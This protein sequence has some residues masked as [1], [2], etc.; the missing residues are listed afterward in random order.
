MGS[1]RADPDYCWL[2]GSAKPE[3][4]PLWKREISIRTRVPP[5]QPGTSIYQVQLD[6][7]NILQLRS[8]R[9][10]MNKKSKDKVRL[11]FWPLTLDQALAGAFQVPVKKK[12]PK[13]RKPKR[14]K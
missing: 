4:H 12:S 9:N 8:C 13:R 2:G 6:I 11:S 14:K 5:I 3:S 7:V 1:I 10:H